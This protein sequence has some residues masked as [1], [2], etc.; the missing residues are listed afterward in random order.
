M[1]Q[2]QALSAQFNLI[3]FLIVDSTYFHEVQ[4]RHA[5]KKVN[6]LVLFV[7]LLLE[8]IVRVFLEDGSV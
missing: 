7:F 5:W 6:Q 1:E 3:Q 2:N 4:L 8:N